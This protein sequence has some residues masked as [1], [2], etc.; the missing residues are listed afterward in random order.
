MKLP[1]QVLA[2]FLPGRP[3][4]LAGSL[5]RRAPRPPPAAHAHPVPLASR[6]PHGDLG[7]GHLTAITPLPAAPPRGLLARPPMTGADL[8]GEVTTPEPYVVAPPAGAAVR[9]RVAAV[10]LGIKA[11]TP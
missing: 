11:A 6:D 8:A 3:T 9:F 4:A 10:D 1:G 5:A 2:T 7:P